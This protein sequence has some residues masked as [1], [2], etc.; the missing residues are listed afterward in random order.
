M[1][2][3]ELEGQIALVTGGGRGIGRSIAM[4]FANAGAEVILV[5]RTKTQLE[6]TRKEINKT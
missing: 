5:A 2:N 3:R 4:A 6:H 1:D